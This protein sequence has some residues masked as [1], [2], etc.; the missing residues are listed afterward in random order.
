MHKHRSFQWV[1]LLL[2][3][4]TLGSVAWSLL[5]GPELGSP[6]TVAGDSAESAD[7]PSVVGFVEGESGLRAAK[8]S[9]AYTKDEGVWRGRLEAHGAAAP[10]A[11][12]PYGVVADPDEPFSSWHRIGVTGEDGQWAVIRSECALG[13]F[14]A[15]LLEPHCRVLFAVRESAGSPGESVLVAPPLSHCKVGL[16][17]GSAQA[18]MAEG[19][20]W[21][22]NVEPRRIEEGGRLDTVSRESWKSDGAAGVCIVQLEGR[23]FEG[24]KADG[25]AMY[26]APVGAELVVGSWSSRHELEP[27]VLGV[28][29]PANL[30]LHAIPHSGGVSIHYHSRSRD[31]LVLDLNA[32]VS[33]SKN[34]VLSLTPMTMRGGRLRLSQDWIERRRPVRIELR[35]PDGEF[36]SAALSEV[37]VTPRT[38][39]WFE[40]GGA[41][42]VEIAVPAGSTVHAVW[43]ESDER[44]LVQLEQAVATATTARQYSLV[45]GKVLVSGPATPGLVIVVTQDGFVESRHGASVSH[46][47][48]RETPAYDVVPA[49]VLLQLRP[50]EALIVELQIGVAHQ[51]AV[52]WLRFESRRIAHA[53]MSQPWSVRIPDGARYRATWTRMAM[54]QGA[55]QPVGTGEHMVNGP[56]AVFS[57]GPPPK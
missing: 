22:C 12:C 9:E 17:V 51:G 1:L 42:P 52:Q 47:A 32:Y 54:N 8:R 30:E 15:F 49:G 25:T 41:K 34:G 38:I 10:V 5:V 3:T 48:T 33:A 20:D 6:K 57:S 19:A 50:Q 31:A 40:G 56:Q 28:S 4:A 45:E 46:M 26:L 35:A 36:F 24:L 18:L 14:V 43:I 16:K 2:V 13:S 23:R 44:S 39:D 53:D 29:V 7:A 27:S 11:G 37:D 55:W 21:E